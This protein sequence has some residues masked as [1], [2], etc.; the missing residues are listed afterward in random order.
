MRLDL[1]F[2]RAS[3]EFSG[4]HL[5]VPRIL[6]DFTVGRNGRS[7]DRFFDRGLF[8]VN[9]VKIEIDPSSP[10]F[11]ELIIRHLS[12]PCTFINQTHAHTRVRGEQTDPP[13]AI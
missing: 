3:Q 4:S 9:Q 8:K 2:S 11:K 10:L 5:E 13:V 6:L 1:E 7:A 12:Y